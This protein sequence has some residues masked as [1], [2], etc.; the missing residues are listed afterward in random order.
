MT[1][2]A[3]Y[4]FVFG[5]IMGG[6]FR[7]GVGETKFDYALSLFLGLCLFHVISETMGAAP[8][9][10]AQ[11]P[12]FVKKVVFPLE[13]I[14][15]SNVVTSL[16][17]AGLSILL[18]LAIA[19]FSHYGVCWTGALALPLLLIPL[20][21]IALGLAW[22]LAAVG[23]YIRDITHLSPFLST[24][25]MFSSA[26]FYSPAKIPPG[27]WAFL[28]Y[29]PMLVIIDEARRLVLW[30]TPLDYGA[31]GYVYVFAIVTVAIGYTL[32][33]LLR[34]YFAEVI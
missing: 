19:P 1:M 12:N 20:A 32:F 7:E 30:Q 29:N 8:N 21:L 31:I 4:L 22:G 24:A 33:H 2:L 14:P 13:I 15:L 18:L 5:F 26:P 17:H 10:I 25:L 16:Y 11:Q 34:P 3:L 9:L 23:V 27:I 6:T 28:Q